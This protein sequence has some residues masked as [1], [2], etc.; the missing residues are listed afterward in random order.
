MA[1]IKNVVMRGASKQMGGV[2]F[3]TRSGETIAR[4]LAPAVSNPRTRP[5]MENRVKLGNIVGVYRANRAWMPGAFED[6][7]E[8]ETDY[9]AFVRMNITNN[10][11]ALTKQHIAEGAAVAAP[12]RITSGSI[13]SVE[14]YR[15]TTGLITNLYTGGLVMTSATTIGQL[16]Q[17]LIQNNNNITEGMQLSL[18]IN[19]QRR[20]ENTQLPFIV[21][22]VYELVLNNESQELVNEYIPIEIFKT[23]E[24]DGNPLMF[25]GATLGD[26]AAAFILSKTEA[27]RTRVSSQ[28]MALFGNQ[29]TYS[30]YT[31]AAAVRAAIESY[32][33]TVDNF[34][35]STGASRAN[36]VVIENFIQALGFNRNLYPAGATVPTNLSQQY[37]NVLYLSQAIEGPVTL[38]V[39]LDNSGTRVSC[40]NVHLETSGLSVSFEWPSTTTVASPTDVTMYLTYGETELEFPFIADPTT[41]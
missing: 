15:N 5:Q 38:E 41:I 29:T 31:S 34:L 10:A 36:N 39:E 26:G 40:E 33:E 2:V 20:N 30:I 6:K 1:V 28:T 37:I 18:V 21:T 4:E 23:M 14:Y 17:A 9:N 12:Y 27:G 32:G 16:S 11:V 25:E 35:D 24:T 19:I 7:A 8:K 13:Q 22:R 3:Y